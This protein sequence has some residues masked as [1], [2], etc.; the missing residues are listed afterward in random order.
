MDSSPNLNELDRL[1]FV[2]RLEMIDA[3]C[4]PIYDDFAEL[5]A[6]ICGT[7]VSLVTLLDLE[8]QWFISKVG[9]DFNEAP[10]APSFC[11]HTIKEPHP[12]II[13]DATKDARFQDNYLIADP[14]H[15]RFYAGVPLIVDGYAV[16]TI[17]VFDRTPRELDQSQI[18]A[19]SIL[20][21]QL[22]RSLEER[23]AIVRQQDE[24]DNLAGLNRI[25]EFA[26]NRFEGLFQNLAVACYT[27]DINGCI[28]EVNQ[29]AENLFG[30]KSYELIGFSDIH[31]LKIESDI[32][33][34]KLRRQLALSGTKQTSIEVKFR[35]PDGSEL[36]TLCNI[37]PIFNPSGEPLGLVFVY[38]DIGDRKALEVELMSINE[39]LEGLSRTDSLTGISNRRGLTDKLESLFATQS[40]DQVGILILDVD[41]FKLYNDEFGHPAG[42]TVLQAIAKIIKKSVPKDCFAG[43]Y[44]GE[45]F[46]VILP[47]K[48]AD[49]ANQ[50]AENIRKNVESHK[51]P[52]SGVTISI[53]A[54]SSSTNDLNRERLISLADVRLYQAKHDGR[55]RVVG[56]TNSSEQAPKVA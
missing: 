4:T 27:T 11:T 37:Q 13:P 40:D 14:F 28:V 16:G 44:G 6:T 55:N 3:E 38:N 10:R 33:S 54:A 36:W 26:R 7:P 5:A 48:R 56:S 45:E 31:T 47:G 25:Y 41:K 15:V 39:T 53:G 42:D 21:R 19:L 35:K 43:R 52:A 17:C 9:I 2:R 34:F 49:E 20:A 24:Q 12:L 29:H 1:A 50:I 18:D 23:L 32:K 22:Q 51:W 46:M 30:I 8:R